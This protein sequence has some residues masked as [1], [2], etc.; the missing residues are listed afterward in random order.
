MFKYITVF[1]S[2]VNLDFYVYVCADTH[3]HPT[4]NHQQMPCL[5]LQEGFLDPFC[6]APHILFLPAAC[7]R[8]VFLAKQDSSIQNAKHH[9]HCIDGKNPFFSPCNS[10]ELQLKITASLPTVTVLMNHSHS[11]RCRLQHLF[12]AEGEQLPH[13]TLPF[14][15]YSHAS[16]V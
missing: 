11:I 14:T 3:A 13:S 12:P 15:M 8:N 1:K 6:L 10:Q 2:V 7:I 16:R 9:A 5:H 4:P